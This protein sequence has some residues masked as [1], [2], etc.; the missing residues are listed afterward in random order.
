MKT[1]KAEPMGLN[2]WRRMKERL[3]I[4]ITENGYAVNRNKRIKRERG[5]A[6]LIYP[7]PH[8]DV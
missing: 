6:S 8:A 1:L 3:P 5:E 4:R 7:H 2:D